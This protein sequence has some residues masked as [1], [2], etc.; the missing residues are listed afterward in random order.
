MTAAHLHVLQRYEFLN[1][2]ISTSALHQLKSSASNHLLIMYEALSVARIYCSILILNPL[3]RVGKSLRLHIMTSS[4]N[5]SSLDSMKFLS[6]SEVTERKQ[7]LEDE[8]KSLEDRQGLLERQKDDM[9][10]I[11][12]VFRNWLTHLQKVSELFEPKKPGTYCILGASTVQCSEQALFTSEVS[13]SNPG[14]SHS[15][16]KRVDQSSVESSGFSSGAP[17]SPH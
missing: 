4:H 7:A 6:L 2:S 10:N 17:V 1:V 12:K 16:A 15:H 5:E 11:N 14:L 3:R 13:S 9:L 8:T